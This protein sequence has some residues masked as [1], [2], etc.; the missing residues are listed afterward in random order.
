[1]LAALHLYGRPRRERPGPGPRHGRRSSLC[2]STM[3]S[4]ATL[5]APTTGGKRLV[6]KNSVWQILGFGARAVSGIGVVVLVARSGGPRSLGVFQ[7]ALTLTAMLPFYFGLPSLLAREVARRPEEG[8]RWADVGTLIAVL[9]GVLFTF[10]LTAGAWLVGASSLDDGPRSRSQGSAWPSTG[11]PT[12]SS[13]PCGPGSGSTSKPRSRSSRKRS[14]WCRPAALL[15]A[16][17]GAQAAVDRV[18]RLARARCA[19]RLARRRAALRRT[20]GA[21]SLAGVPAGHVEAVHPVR[22]ND[23]LTLTYMRADAV[24]LGL[25]KGPTA[26]GLYQAGTNLVLYLNVVARSINERALPRG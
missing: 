20:P 4:S 18:H 19:P 12:S 14:S 24:M 11:S 8:R 23:T 3:R 2:T 6:A 25:F 22:G 13:R 17:G 1:M 16:G 9:F 21:K 5:D 26:V 7:F 15:S 10:V